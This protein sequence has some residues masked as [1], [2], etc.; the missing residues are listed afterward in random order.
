M[1]R[2]VRKEDWELTQGQ[3]EMLQRWHQHFSKILN[4]QSEF[5]EG[6]IQEM[7]MLPP[8]LDLDEP[9]TE[10]E[11]VT[12]LTKMKMCKAGGKTGIL[13]EMVLLVEEVSGT[14]CCN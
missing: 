14:G 3:E 10:E 5:S 13:P 8:G 12:A 9:P 4:Q 1:P 7:P 2:V 6:V 11:L